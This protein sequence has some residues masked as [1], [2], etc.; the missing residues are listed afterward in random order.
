MTNPLMGRVARVGAGG[1]NRASRTLLTSTRAAS[2]RDL[3]LGGI[4]HE[5][6]D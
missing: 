6:R 3:P 4:A 2:P 1:L 5:A